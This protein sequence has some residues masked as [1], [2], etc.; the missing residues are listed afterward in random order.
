MTKSNFCFTFLF[1]ISFYGN[2]QLVDDTTQA[3]HRHHENEFIIKLENRSTH[4]NSEFTTI[5]GLAV[6]LDIHHKFRVKLSGNSTFWDV[7]LWNRS[8]FYFASLGLE[9]D[10]NDFQLVTIIPFVNMGYGR[11]EY[12]FPDENLVGKESII[13]LEL[14]V[15][16]S[17]HFLPWADLKIGG[18]S[19]R[20]LGSRFR[21]LNNYFLKFGIGIHLKKWNSWREERSMQG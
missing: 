10:I 7:G 11:H 12:L 19:R 16:G 20:V 3:H 18:G 1:T 14:G 15:Y 5:Y 17:Y 13:P 8:K 2:C 4:I 6:G 9:Y 21:N